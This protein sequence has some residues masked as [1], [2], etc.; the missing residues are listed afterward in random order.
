[1][2]CNCFSHN[3]FLTAK[4]LQEA[5]QR[6]ADPLRV[7]LAGR[8]RYVDRVGS[9]SA[10]DR[11]RGQTLWPSDQLLLEQSERFLNGT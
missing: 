11:D 5:A 4:G 1:M 3:S 8:G 7:A 10:V 6:R 2:K 9:V